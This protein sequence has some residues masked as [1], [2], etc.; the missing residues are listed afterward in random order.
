MSTISQNSNLNNSNENTF[1]QIINFGKNE[2]NSFKNLKKNNYAPGYDFTFLV[3]RVN[4]LSDI[5]L[6]LQKESFPI[7]L[8]SIEGIG[9]TTIARAYC[10]TPE[11]T[12]KYDYIFW[13]DASD[14]DVRKDVLDNSIFSF[15]RE[16][17]NIDN[18]FYR[19]VRQSKELTGNVLL[20]VDNIQQVEQIQS[21]EKKTSLSLLRWKI[22]VTTRA[23]INDTT[24]KKRVINIMEL[25][26]KHC[27]D[28][29]YSHYDEIEAN[30]QANKQYLDK[31]FNLL[32]YHTYLIVLL[33]KVGD[34]T[35]SIKQLL[36]MLENGGLGN[37]DLQIEIT[38]PSEDKHVKLYNFIESIFN[39]VQIAN[40]EKQILTYFSILPDRPVSESD[41][42]LWMKDETNTDAELKSLF[43]RLF[44]KGWLIQERQNRDGEKFF[45]YKCHGLIQTILRNKLQPNSENCN[46]LIQNMTHFIYVQIWEKYTHK[47]PYFDCI[48]TI[49][50]YVKEDSLPIYML[51]KNYV[52]LLSRNSNSPKMAYLHS[53]YLMD[54]YDE[55][56]HPSKKLKDWQV[57]LLLDVYN[58]YAT[59]YINYAQ[60][61]GKYLKVY[62]LREKALSIAKRNI[63][64]T[65]IRYLNA[66]RRFAKSQR[67]LNQFENAINTLNNVNKKVEKLL[68]QEKNASIRYE[69]LYIQKEIVDA[70]GFIY[71][72]MSGVKENN[73]LFEGRME[74]LQYALDARKKY[75]EYSLS[76]YNETHTFIIEPEP[77][78]N[79]GMTFLYLY[80]AGNKNIEYLKNAEKYLYEAQEIKLK[81]F[82]EYSL[83]AAIGFSNFAHLF[84]VQGNYAEALRMALKTLSIRQAILEGEQDRVFMLSYGRIASIYFSQWQK[85]KE[86][87]HIKKA[88]INIDKAIEIADYIYAGDKENVDYKS[89]LILKNNIKKAIVNP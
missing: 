68:Q 39:F 64:E 11:Y 24:F 81:E 53:K 20:V 40:D 82:G 50:Q 32:D 9:K 87:A 4:S 86:I 1:Q 8:H 84:E 33:A 17:E 61:K 67:Q 28:L 73:R 37:K 13:I 23:I 46:A 89:Y 6:V 62:E 47:I 66:E 78:N 36:S 19:F 60:E 63:K 5:D 34:G 54:K 31:I 71:V 2:G 49:L 10:N 65:D 52:E 45:I 85:E 29:F 42:I 41:L 83:T 38:T 57:G 35:Y 44:E 27:Q 7:Y 72:A 48:D 80:K 21:I 18:E 69:L 75:L 51:K 79:L 30:K 3:D 15:N 43:R 55:V 77:L 58:L 88:E 14:K 56:I 76:L 26:N 16:S 12:S 74:Y 70:F 25:E 22:L 59:S